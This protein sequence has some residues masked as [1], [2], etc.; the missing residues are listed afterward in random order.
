MEQ[1]NFP[2]GI[3]SFSYADLYDS[4]RLKD[5]LAAFDASV[6]L[7]DADLFA[8]YADYR[9]SQGEGLTPEALSELLV[10]MGPYVGQFVATLFGVTEQHQAQAAKIKDEFETVF[11]YKNLVVDKLNLLFKDE[12]SATWDK[13]SIDKRLD[14]LIA[15]AFPDADTDVDPERRV[16]RAGAVIGRLSA[17][18]KLIA[19]G[20]D[21]DFP[22][23]DVV[24]K[25]LRSK[26]SA[27]DQAAA[28]F[29]DIIALSEAADFV[30]GLM[31]VV[32]RW[33]YLT[34]QN[35]DISDNWLSFKFPQKRD[36]EH[37][38]E[39]DVVDKGEFSVW[40]GE[41]KHRRRRDG[42]KLTDPRMSQREVL[43]EV[44][45]CIYCH[46]RDTDSCSKGM[47]NKKPSSSRLI[48][49]A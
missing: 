15:A 29:Q 47:I 28:E 8:R 38:V 25:D 44:D 48:R 6:K 11:T 33:S 49:W 14:C 42:F 39:H 2:L 35:S 45:H 27:N 19:K 18:Y 5:L 20:K 4:N 31:D 13:A 26:L 1:N 24:V 34:Q 32:Q 21:G 9:Q 7:H 16:A 43:S 22:T 3:P 10:L 46:E 37:L 41:L 23:A 40:M 36:F 12:D 17:H 30:Q